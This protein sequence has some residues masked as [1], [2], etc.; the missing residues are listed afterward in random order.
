MHG[1]T[2]KKSSVTPCENR[3]AIADRNKNA[4]TPN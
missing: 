4:I 3:L 1:A 2:V